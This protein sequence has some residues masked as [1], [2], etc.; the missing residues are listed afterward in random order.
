MGQGMPS[1]SL[2]AVQNQEQSEA[3]VLP[4]SGA[5]MAWRYLLVYRNLMKSNKGQRQALHQG[6]NNPSGSGTGQLDGSCA[7]RDLAILADSVL[8]MSQPCNPGVEKAPRA[9]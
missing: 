7:E 5:S 8:T 1:A 4:L 2:W 6:R 9:A 3:A